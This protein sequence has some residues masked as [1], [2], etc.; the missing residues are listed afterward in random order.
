[1]KAILQGAGIAIFLEDETGFYGINLAL[2]GGDEYQSSSGGAQPNPN[3]GQMFR[4]KNED[5]TAAFSGC[6][7]SGAFLD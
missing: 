6:S 2:G 1:V 4:V 5:G 7:P 3:D